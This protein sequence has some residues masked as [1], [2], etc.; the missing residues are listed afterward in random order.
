MITRHTILAISVAAIVMTSAPIARAIVD[1]PRSRL[2]YNPTASAPRGWYWIEPPRRLGV[3]DYVL[4]RLPRAVATMASERRYLPRAV[5]I[6]KG[7]GALS[8]QHV[9]IRD[10]R[11]TIDRKAVASILIRDGAGRPLTAWGQCRAL[12]KDEIFLLSMFNAASFDSRYFGPVA[13]TDVIGVAT[14]VWTW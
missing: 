12:Q 4:V 7:I 8:P 13:R 14:P 11:V 10:H 9:C 2:A 3:H 5:P 6:L 1:Y